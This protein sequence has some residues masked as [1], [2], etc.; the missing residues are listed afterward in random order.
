MLLCV[1]FYISNKEKSKEEM[2]IAACGV[3]CGVLHCCS[4]LQ[5]FCFYI[6]KME[7]REEL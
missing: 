3:C 5:S 1:C 2:Y 6:A 4:L 7:G